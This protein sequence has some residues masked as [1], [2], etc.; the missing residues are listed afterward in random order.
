MSHEP[1]RILYVE[2]DPYDVTILQET[3]RSAK[4][5]SNEYTITH[6]EDLI[7]GLNTVHE[8]EFDVILLD[9]NLPEGSGEKNV[10]I[11]KKHAPDLP[12]ICL[13]SM[14]CDRVAMEAMQAGAQEYLVK[15]YDNAYILNRVIR[16]SIFRQHIENA[17]RNDAQYDNKTGLPNNLFVSQTIESFVRKAKEWG[18]EDALLLMTISNFTNICGQY[19]HSVSREVAIRTA[20]NMR[21]V[22]KEEFA[23]SLNEGE[24]VIYL[25]NNA[26]NNIDQCVAELS[27][28]LIEAC[29]VSHKIKGHDINV[30]V[31]IGASIF[32]DTGSNYSEL[33][34]SAYDALFIAGSYGHSK[35]CMADKEFVNAGRNRIS[36]Q[37]D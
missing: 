15:G 7:E 18:H 21:K 34:D 25:H 6:A 11:F 13:T 5:F 22:L 20:E 28:R 3:L 1:I 16:S 36:S 9:L 33:L 24:L 2:D 37:R 10:K 27:E 32:P 19:G 35:Y 31:N 23:G 17:L 26:R 12:I 4:S 14:N 30:T 8:A 29:S